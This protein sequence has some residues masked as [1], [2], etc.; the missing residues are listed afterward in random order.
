MP[1]SFLNHAVDFD[2]DGRPD[3]WNSTPD[4]LASIANYLVHYGWVRG[5]AGVSR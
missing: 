4:V 2:G 1:T 3:M 5:A